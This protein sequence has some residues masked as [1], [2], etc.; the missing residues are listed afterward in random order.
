M[1]QKLH[2]FQSKFPKSMIIK[3]LKSTLPG[4]HWLSL[5]ITVEDVIDLFIWM[6]ENKRIPGST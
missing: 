4:E 1:S 6:V 5:V 3:T 2:P